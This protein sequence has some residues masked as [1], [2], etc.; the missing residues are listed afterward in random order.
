MQSRFWQTDLERE[1]EELEQEEL[2]NKLVN[3]TPATRDR[4]PSIPTEELEPAAASKLRNLQVQVRERANHSE[5]A[6]F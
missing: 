1:L 2:A 5:E 4:L 6:I 3:A